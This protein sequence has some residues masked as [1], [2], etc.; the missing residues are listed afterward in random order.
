MAVP[1]RNTLSDAWRARLVIAALAALVAFVCTCGFGPSRGSSATGLAAGDEVVASCDSGMKVAYTT[2][3]DPTDSGYAI[4]GIELSNIPAD[5]QSQRF[6][7][8]FYAS[9]GAPIGSAVD[10]TLTSA[11]TTQSIAIAPDSNNIDASDVSGI[12][13]VVS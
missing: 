7:A 8:T 9:N 1:R 3:F 4:S 13:V 5:C 12:T 2:A 6:S 11:G 10:A